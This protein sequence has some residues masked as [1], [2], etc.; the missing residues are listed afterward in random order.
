MVEQQSGSRS[1]EFTTHVRRAGKSVI[2]QWSSLIPKEFWTYGRDATRELL[3]AMRSA[4]DGAIEV[5]DPREAAP[6]PA[7][8]KSK[9]R[10]KKKIDI[11]G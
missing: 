2:M 8:P 6:K 1:Q 10:S 11:E 3:L 4:V 7:P 5:I 9:P